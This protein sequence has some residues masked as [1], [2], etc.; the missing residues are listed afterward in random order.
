ML[1]PEKPRGGWIRRLSMPVVANFSLDSKKN[2]SNTALPGGG[3]YRNSMAFAEE[4]G[5][6]QMHA[7]LA[8]GIRNRSSTNVA[9][10]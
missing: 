10:R 5:R 4:D 1:R 2:G 8:G 6:L 3:G 9:R 7:D